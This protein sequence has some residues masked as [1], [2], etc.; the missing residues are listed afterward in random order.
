[1][2]SPPLAPEFLTLAEIVAQDAACRAAPAALAEMVAAVSDWP[3]LEAGARRHRIVAPVARALAA[4]PAGAVPPGTLARLSAQARAQAVS[5][6]A[7]QAE[8]GRLVGMF[9]AAE[10]PVLVVKGLALS[11]RLHGVIHHRGVGDMDLLVDP[12]QFA[13]AHDLLVGAGYVRQDNGL[14]TP[15]PNRLLPHFM[16]VVYVRAPGHV[17]ELHLALH[18]SPAPPQWAFAAL[19]DRRGQVTLDGMIW[20][21]LGEDDLFP[22][23]V[24]HGA[25]HCWDRLCW[26]GDV[27]TLIRTASDPEA[28]WRRCHH[29]GFG[30]AAD[31]L[32]AL[33]AWWW[34][35]SSAEA[36]P[37]RLQWFVWAFFS[38]SRWLDRPGRGR[39]AWVVLELRCR[40]WRLHLDGGWRHLPLAWR[41]FWRE[42]ADLGVLPLPAGL[43]WLYPALR[44]LGWVLRNFVRRR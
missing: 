11:R 43:S 37:P 6:L 28:L 1:M 5:A 31:H 24:A 4:L 23:L 10:V 22:Y 2:R 16:E 3:R 44:P 35:L 40:R 41:R 9:A 15:P 42:P 34:G 29:L 30:R 21:V 19:W 32:R 8:L 13:R 39:W 26:L 12:G 17:V 7:Q 36:V 38:R 33:L 14:T 25:R 27:A 20:P 18:H